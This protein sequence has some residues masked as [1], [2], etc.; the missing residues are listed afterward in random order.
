MINLEKI[1]Y[2]KTSNSFPSLNNYIKF[3][4]FNIA[5]DICFFLYETHLPF[6]IASSI[7]K[8]VSYYLFYCNNQSRNYIENL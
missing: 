2:S 3:S 4:F 8:T 5:N 7:Y 6:N 1:V